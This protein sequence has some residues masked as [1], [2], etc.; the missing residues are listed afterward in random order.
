MDSA[1]V[2]RFFYTKEDADAYLK[3]PSS[4]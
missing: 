3:D 4:I 2:L 1:A